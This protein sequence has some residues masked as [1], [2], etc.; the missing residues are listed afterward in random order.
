MLD[1]KEYVAALDRIREEVREGLPEQAIAKDYLAALNGTLQQAEYSQADADY[2]KAGRL[3]RAVQ[4]NRPSSAE[5]Q[6]QV[7][8]TPAQVSSR[9]DTCA[10]RLMEKGL[11]AYRSGLFKTAIKF[12]EQILVF[13]P[14]NTA[15]QKAIQTTKLQQANLRRLD[16][17]L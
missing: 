7:D 8:R 2:A 13:Q 15:A 1:A 14:K 11:V 10:E 5:L 12:W 9:I 16:S 4:E 3:F 6:A 17:S